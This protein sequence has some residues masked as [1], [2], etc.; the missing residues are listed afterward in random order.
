MQCAEKKYL[1]VIIPFLNEGEEIVM[2]VKSVRET[3]GDKVDI[4]TINDCSTDGFP[5]RERLQ[6]YSVTY[7]E[8]EV[9]MGVAASRDYGINYCATPYFLL[10]DG[11]MRF[12]DAAWSSRII[13]EL[14]NNDRQLLCCQGRYLEKVDG[15]VRGIMA[16]NY[17]SYGAYFPMPKNYRLLDVMW[18]NEESRPKS[19]TE[20]I[21]A[22]LGAGY[23][24]SKRY[25]QYLRGLEGLKYYG[26]DE[27]YI[28]LKVWMEGG[29]CTLLKDVV[30]GHIY[31]KSSPFK[32]YTD[33]EIYN[34]LL[35]ANLLLPQSLRAIMTVS[36]QTEFPVHCE[37]VMMQLEA[38]KEFIDAL[39]TYYKG[40]LRTPF[41]TFIDK[42]MEFCRDKLKSLIPE[43]NPQEI[44]DFIED[45]VA[46][47]LGLAEGK[48]GQLLWL[49][50][51]AKACPSDAREETVER[52]WNE[53]IGGIRERKLPVNFKHGLAGIGWGL[54]FLKE[55]KL[56]ED[57]IS[58]EI[59]EIDKQISCFRL[60]CEQDN[61][62]MTGVAGLLA[63]ALARVS[64]ARCCKI[65][66]LWSE[67]DTQCMFAVAERI[68][69]KC[70]ETNALIYARRFQLY[71][72]EGYDERD[73]PV[74]LADWMNFRKEIPK[75][76][77]EWDARLVGNIL[78]A[79]AHYLITKIKLISDG[80]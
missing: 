14:Q 53:I 55:R 61:G 62:V 49:C 9:R 73:L 19:V 6:P 8:N 2:T 63:Y 1:T 7:L 29:Q 27:P 20:P 50:L 33:E 80:Q 45:N 5:Y 18:R 78:S 38:G 65:P 37:K 76:K 31:R 28:S 42:Q 74:A 25:W 4:I 13:E 24:A 75:E 23:A 11:H 44:A 17:K 43:Y 58:Q 66:V 15:E 64:Y 12:Y 57:D 41:R 72:G 47:T 56:I 54:I 52:L 79:S 10:L 71:I 35:I 34:R 77:Q 16:R 60:E 48:M 59:N 40:I 32:R 3:A 51:H 22:V 68:L 21:P 26:S 39:R 67:E 30:V 46:D 69:D 70:N 36:A